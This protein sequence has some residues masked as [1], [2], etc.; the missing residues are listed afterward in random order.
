MSND[1][2][3]I[4]KHVKYVL[5]VRLNLL[6]VGKLCDENYNNTFSSESWKLTK[7]SMVV[8]RGTKHSTLYI[9]KAKIIKYVVNAAKFVDGI[10]LWHKRLCHMSEKGMSALLE[11]IYCLILER[12]ICR[13]VLI[14]LVE[15]KIKCLSIT[16]YL[17]GS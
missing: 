14:A 15:S 11:R 4:L 5:D 8:G 1:F 2:R 9:T 17:Q 13:K 12:H 16:T 6:S 7:G 10:D 3:L